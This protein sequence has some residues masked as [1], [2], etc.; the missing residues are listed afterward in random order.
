MKFIPS[1]ILAF[2]LS[3]CGLFHGDVHVTGPGGIDIN[4]SFTPTKPLKTCVAVK[5]VAAAHG[6]EAWGARSK[7]WPAGSTLRVKFLAGSASQKAEA[8]K[9]FQVIQ[10]YTNLKFVQS[11]GA[12][13]IRVRFDYNNGHWSYVGKDCLGIPKSQPTMNLALKSGWFGDGAT[14]WDRVA[15]HEILHSIG[16]MHEHQHPQAK[17]P[18]DVPAVIAYYQNTQGWSEAEI[19]QQVL[20]VEPMTPDFVGT[21]FD[22]TSIMEY[23]ID[24][25]LTTNGFSV[26]WN[27]KLSALDIQYIQTVYPKK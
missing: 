13:E 2:T 24:P 22:P 14:E 11:T 1:L 18:W 17:I 3:A 25:H 10:G 9:R 27:T 21:R 6:L 19:R 12:S 26:G 8:W 20:T 16:L 4:Q 7:F 5:P 23:P 15:L